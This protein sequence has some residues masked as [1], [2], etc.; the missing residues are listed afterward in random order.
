MSKKIPFVKT[1]NFRK[2]MNEDFDFAAFQPEIFDIHK[3]SFEE[4]L[5]LNIDP[6]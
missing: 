6:T 4:F 1:S 5:Q 2:S 3:K